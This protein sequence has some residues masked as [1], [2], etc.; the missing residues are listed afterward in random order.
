MTRAADETKV[1]DFAGVIRVDQLQLRGHVRV[2]VRQS[3]EETLSAM[4]EAEADAQR[5]AKRYE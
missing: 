4:R 3:V 5:G 2:W 1:R